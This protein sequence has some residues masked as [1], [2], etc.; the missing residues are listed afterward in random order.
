MSYT[1][2]MYLRLSED[3]G[4]ADKL[5]SDSISSQRLTIKSQEEN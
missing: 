4:Q 1:I 3:D 5:E 2:G